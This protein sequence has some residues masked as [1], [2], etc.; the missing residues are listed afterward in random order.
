MIL[1][2]GW[3]LLLCLGNQYMCCAY[4][5][6]LVTSDSRAESAHRRA[7]C[8]VKSPCAFERYVQADV[9]SVE[10]KHR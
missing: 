9:P 8:T 3:L 2:K 7:K 1:A 6:A 4:R 5:I 10:A